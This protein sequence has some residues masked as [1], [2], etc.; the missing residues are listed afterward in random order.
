MNIVLVGFMGAGKTAIGKRLAARLGY[1]F[2]DTDAYIEVKEGK[3]IA[4]IFAQQGEA[5]FRALETQALVRLESVSNHV[6][7]TG[8]SILTTPGNLELIKKIG[9]SIFLNP[10]LD[11]IIERVMRN[12]KRPL[13]RTENPVETIKALHAKRLPLYLQADLNFVPEGTQ[14]N[15]IL[16]QI[17]RLL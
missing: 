1:R 13:V 10:D 7:A 11:K 5:Y 12:D 4:E 3:S 17:I 14:F 15:S 2:L 6:I 8:G 16:D 9:T